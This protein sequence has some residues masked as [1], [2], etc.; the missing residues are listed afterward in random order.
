MKGKEKNEL[1][2]DEMMCLQI[3]CGVTRRNRLRNQ[4]V[5][6]LVDIPE[7]PSESIEWCCNGSD[8]LSEWEG[9]E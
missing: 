2:V 9:G 4:E 8:M 1:D 7:K 3:M 5:R 6:K